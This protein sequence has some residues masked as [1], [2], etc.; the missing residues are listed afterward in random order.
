MMLRSLEFFI[1]TLDNFSS[2]SKMF[3]FGNGG[4]SFGS[5]DRID[6]ESSIETIAA[7]PE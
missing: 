6:T 3:L 2:F 7:P 4:D 1:E 5:E